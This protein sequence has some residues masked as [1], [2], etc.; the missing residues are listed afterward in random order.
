M[1]AC[2]E[3]PV[4][5]FKRCLLIRDLKDVTLPV[6][7]MQ[8]FI[9]LSVGRLSQTAQELLCPKGLLHLGVLL[10]AFVPLRCLRHKPKRLLSACYVRLRPLM[11]K[12]TAGSRLVMKE[13]NWW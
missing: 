1:F 2:H 13:P 11:K 9:S 8:N 3:W 6:N 5:Q 12:I 10:V 4:R 7:C